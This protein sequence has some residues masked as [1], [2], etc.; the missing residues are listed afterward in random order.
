VSGRFTAALAAE[1]L[2]ARRSKVPP[3]TL[4][5][6]AAPA[7]I[8]ALFMF[9]AGDPER[10]QRLGLAGQ[11]ARLS[12]L[13][14]DWTGLLGFLAQVVAVGGLLVFSFIATWVFGREFSDA[15]ARYLL[16]LPVPRPTIVLAKFT[17]VA[18]WSLAVAAWLIG[19]FLGVGWLL[20]LPG[21]SAQVAADGVADALV[22]ALLLLPAV[23]PV[24]LVACLGRG[25]LAPLAGALAALVFAQVA[26][27]LGWG[28]VVPWSVPAVAAG[29]AP[30]SHLGAPGLIVA[31]LTGLGGVAATIAWWRGG[32]AGL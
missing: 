12:G 11:K 21:W 13:T 23:A 27:V 26:A 3:L 4:A 1:W 17:L 2:K 10:A 29:L 31:G 18:G 32:D 24:A 30:G 14:A 6:F 16:A 15:T 20:Q 7:G 5:A 28:A 8:A 19:L 22:A 25:Y 9:I